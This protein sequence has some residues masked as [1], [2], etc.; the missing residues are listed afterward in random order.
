M[1]R[2]FLENTL[3][4]LFKPVRWSLTIIA[5]FLYGDNWDSITEEEK[6]QKTFYAPDLL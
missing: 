4:F 3:I 2:R 6:K 5:K 1:M